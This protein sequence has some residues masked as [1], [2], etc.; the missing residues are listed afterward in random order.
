MRKFAD[1]RTERF[2][3]GDRVPAFAAIERKADGRLQYLI[4]AESLRDVG[5]MPGWRLEVLRGDR[6]D[7]GQSESM[8]NGES[9]S[10]GRRSCLKRLR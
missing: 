1:K 6:Q 9:V 3:A 4:G 10:F 5:V 8:I 2:A 7:N